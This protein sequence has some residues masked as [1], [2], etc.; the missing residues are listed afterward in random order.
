VGKKNKKKKLRN[1]N[2]NKLPVQP[3][4][5]LARLSALILGRNARLNN[6]R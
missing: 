4:V 1:K 5:G 6:W 3:T 2:E